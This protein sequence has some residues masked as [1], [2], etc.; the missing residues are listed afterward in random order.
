M[1]E[2]DKAPW[3]VKLGAIF[4][5]II[6]MAVVGSLAAWAIVQMWS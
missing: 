4:L 5:V 6:A 3:A 2:W 1:D